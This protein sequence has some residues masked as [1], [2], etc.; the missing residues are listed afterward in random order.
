MHI[1]GWVDGYIWKGA[2]D[3]LLR[4]YHISYGVNVNALVK[5]IF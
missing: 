1:E 3:S 4:P 5:E 2:A